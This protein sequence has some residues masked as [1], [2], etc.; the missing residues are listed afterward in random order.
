MPTEIAS[1][2][3]GRRPATTVLST[4][5]ERL[6]SVPPWILLLELFLGLGWLR[7]AVEKLPSADWW[8]GETIREFVRVHEP[9][10]W[11]EP[12]LEVVIVPFAAPIGTGVVVAQLLIGF[13]FL[14]GRGRGAALAL[15]TLLNLHFVAAGAVN[16]SAFY[17]VMQGALA[18]WLVETA[19]PSG[20]ERSLGALSV[21]AG[22]LALV[23]SPYV[24]TLEPSAVIHDPAV[25]LVTLGSFTVLGCEMTS[26]RLAHSPVSAR[27][28][29]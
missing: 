1:S 17:L 3:T 11:F 23:S 29:A 12:L 28:S 25:M 15:G 20:L 16:P 2:V 8:T 19:P 26:R 10:G 7:A 6:Q 4:V 5:A 9:I 18:L 27:G 14:T 22:A 13:L 24:M 21:A